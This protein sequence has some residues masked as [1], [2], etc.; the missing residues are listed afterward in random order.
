MRVSGLFYEILVALHEIIYIYIYIYAIIVC[1]C[2]KFGGV[3][4]LLFFSFFGP[5]FTMS[6]FNGL[7]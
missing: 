1:V 3:E 5:N 2:V 4:T 7:N 6:K